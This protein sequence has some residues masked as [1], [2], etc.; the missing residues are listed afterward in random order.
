MSSIKLQ[1]LE[2]RIFLLERELD[3]T[4]LRDTSMIYLLQVE[5]EIAYKEYMQLAA[6]PI[7]ALCYAN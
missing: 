1:G 7:E 3:Q 2:V 4:S 5:L 6:K